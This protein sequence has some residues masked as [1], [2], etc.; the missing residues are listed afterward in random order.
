MSHLFRYAP[1]QTAALLYLDAVFFLQRTGKPTSSDAKILALCWLDFWIEHD[2][3]N[4]E[5]HQQVK[6]HLAK[7]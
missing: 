4:T 1:K 3:A 7:I 5:K 2:T 6:K